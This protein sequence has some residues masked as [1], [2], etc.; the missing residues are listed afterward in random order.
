MKIQVMSDIHLECLKMSQNWEKYYPINC[1]VLCLC[2]DI[3]N[4]FKETYWSFIEY[5]KTKAKNVLIITGNHE[6]WGSS[7][8]EVDTHITIT[9]APMDNVFFLQRNSTQY[10]YEFLQFPDFSK[11]RDA[12]PKTFTQWHKDDKKW[13]KNA[14]IDAVKTEKETIVL[15]HYTPMFNLAT[16]KQ[17]RDDHTQYMFSTDLRELFPLVDTWCYGHTH[18]NTPS[19]IYKIQDFETLFVSNQGGYPDGNKRT[20]SFHP[21]FSITFPLDEKIKPDVFSQKGLDLKYRV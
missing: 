14:L 18:F 5:V 10:W 9:C 16:D 4:P 17:Y 3:G 11:I 21:D 1:D 20:P 8:L 13:L 15:T 7:K 6:S 12:T 19:H 2:G